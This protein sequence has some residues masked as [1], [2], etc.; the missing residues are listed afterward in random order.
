M[1]QVQTT[2]A[3]TPEFDARIEGQRM[4][5]DWYANLEQANARGQKVANVFVMGNA[6]E[7]LI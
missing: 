1:T 7:I 5:K 6:I 2:P 3:A 4:M